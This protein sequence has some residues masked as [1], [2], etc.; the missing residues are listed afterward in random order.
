MT[1]RV[2]TH[3]ELIQYT[4]DALSTSTWVGRFA[5][6]FLMIV[7]YNLIWPGGEGPS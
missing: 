4:E 7:G 1:P 5:S 3:A 2:Q 6:L